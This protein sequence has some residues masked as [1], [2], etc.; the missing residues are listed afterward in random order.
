ML[1]ILAKSLVQPFDGFLKELE[2][3]RKDVDSAILSEVFYDAKSKT[4]TMHRSTKTNI[5]LDSY[6]EDTCST[7]EYVFLSCI[8]EL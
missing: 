5:G 3:V 6:Q 1:H 4:T 7:P 8:L 2:Q